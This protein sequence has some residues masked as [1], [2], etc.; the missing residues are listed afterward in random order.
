MSQTPPTTEAEAATSS[1]IDSP[2]ADRRVAFVGKLGGVNRKEARAI[3][4]RLGGVMLDRLDPTADLI[5]IG[6]DVIPLDE[7]SELLADWISEGVEQGRIDVIDETQFWQRTGVAEPE[8]DVSQLYTPAMLAGLLE[9]PISTI[10]RWHRRGLIT[11]SRQIKKLAYFDFQEVALARRIADLIASGTNPTTIENRLSELAS[12]FPNFSRPLN[13]LSVLVEGQ[14]V[15]L[16]QGDSVVETNGQRRLPFDHTEETFDERDAVDTISFESAK[17]RF[18][19]NKTPSDVVSHQDFLRLANEL[20]DEG[21][22][23]DAIEVYRS[24]LFAYGTSTDICFRIAELLYQ[25]NDLSGARERYSMAI[26]ME[27]SFVEA[28]ASLGCVLLELG[29][30]VLAKAA[31]LG[32]LKHHEEY[33][34]VHF[35]LARLLDELGEPNDAQT[36]WRRFLELTPRSPWTAEAKARLGVTD[37]D[38]T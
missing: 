18:S 31:F 17:Q 14:R 11:P 35:H 20:E 30:P 36:H 7:P 29:E 34:D 3:V 16:R 38:A 6:A 9:I 1:P 2:I 37:N 12:R 19:E 33:P 10:R 25:Q 32:A 27:P 22:F 24:L 13:Q 21:K 15:L 23:A 4:K 26:E 8:S 5:V 28:R